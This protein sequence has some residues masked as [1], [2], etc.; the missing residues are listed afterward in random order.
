MFFFSRAVNRKTQI[1]FFFLNIFVAFSTYYKC[2]LNCT[3]H[4]SRSERCTREKIRANPSNEMQNKGNTTNRRKGIIGHVGRMSIVL[5]IFVCFR[6]L[7]Y[8]LNSKL[9]TINL[10]HIYT[11]E[12]HLV[13]FY[14]FQYNLS[15]GS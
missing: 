5:D 7:K 8:E 15:T 11:I 12:F 9:Y 1:S 3:K 10:H 4:P 14:Y 6:R 2:H 13:L